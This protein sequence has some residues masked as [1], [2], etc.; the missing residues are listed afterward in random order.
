[1][2]KDLI[3]LA[4]LLL[5]GGAAKLGYEIYMNTREYTIDDINGVWTCKHNDGKHYVMYIHDGRM[6]FMRYEKEDE[7][8][9][10]FDYYRAMT[11][12]E[13]PDGT[14][15]TF[16]WRGIPDLERSESQGSEASIS[17]LYEFEFRRNRIYHRLVIA[18]ENEFV[19]A[20]EEEYSHIVKMSKELDRRYQLSRSGK[21]L[22][23]GEAHCYTRVGAT[24]DTYDSFLCVQI[25]NPNSYRIDVA[26][27][28]L[29]WDG[30][31]EGVTAA[32]RS[33]P[34]N[35]TGVY[36]V[37]ITC[38]ELFG[39]GKTIDP[40]ECSVEYNGYAAS[41]DTNDNPIVEVTDSRVIKDESTGKVKAVEVDAKPADLA[42]NKDSYYDLY[43]LFY[44]QGKIV[45][46]ATG[47]GSVEDIDQPD[48]MQYVSEIK[49]YDRCEVI[50]VNRYSLPIYSR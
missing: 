50:V 14:F 26:H 44:L 28:K 23:V 38:R 6:D 47:Y 30:Y 1:M 12:Q 16:S 29:R 13:L 48:I 37:D 22:E 42:D 35:S 40:T 19:R 7:S 43:A 32:V 33:I 11:M 34:A 39:L 46:V 45:G 17:D 8:V 31:S 3:I 25:T 49:E 2:K 5:L 36:V 10:G 41:A 21:P 18:G 24:A 15:N 20:T 9:S 27:V 4:V